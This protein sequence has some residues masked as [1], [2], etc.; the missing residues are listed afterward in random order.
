M[1]GKDDKMYDVTDSVKKL[2]IAAGG[3]Q[4]S[5]QVENSILGDPLENVIKELII[6]YSYAGKEYTITIPEHETVTIP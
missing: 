6:K 3:E 4:V 1:Y 5:F 2:V